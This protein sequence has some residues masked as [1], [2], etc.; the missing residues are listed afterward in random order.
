MISVNTYLPQCPTAPL[1]TANI[2]KTKN[3]G[4]GSLPPSL[5]VCTWDIDEAAEKS[6]KASSELLVEDEEQE[7]V[8]D[9]VHE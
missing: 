6:D 8:H 5:S 7:G 4:V 2:N 9:G 1:R 3:F